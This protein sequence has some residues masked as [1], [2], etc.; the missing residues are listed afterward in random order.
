MPPD[1]RLFHVRRS[2]GKR[3][4]FEVPYRMRDR[5]YSIACTLNR[6]DASEDCE[7]FMQANDLRSGYYHRSAVK[8]R[9]LPTHDVRC[10]FRKYLSLA[11]RYKR[12]GN[13]AT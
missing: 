4:F 5:F 8:E 1:W 7:K 2:T 13:N 10:L 3:L 6:K 9:D 12:P 11:L